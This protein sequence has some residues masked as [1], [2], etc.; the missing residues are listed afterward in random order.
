M[1]NYDGAGFTSASEVEK[2][3][4]QNNLNLYKN[5]LK[6]IPKEMIVYRQAIAIGQLWIG[7]GEDHHFILD[8]YKPFYLRLKMNATDDLCKECMLFLEDIEVLYG[9]FYQAASSLFAADE[10]LIK[11]KGCHD[12]LEIIF[13]AHKETKC[14]VV[15]KKKS[16][17]ISEI[18]SREVIC[19]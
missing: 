5:M 8:N 6:D 19:V 9:E 15:T 11:F 17:T 2:Q 4:Y 13:I 14:I 18:D 16:R 7:Y 12:F 10:A 3:K 1:T